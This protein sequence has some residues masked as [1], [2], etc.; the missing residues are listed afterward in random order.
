MARVIIT[1]SLFKTIQRTFDVAEADSILDALKSLE[2]NPYKGKIP[3]TVGGIVIKEIRHKK[4][5]FYCITDGH[6]LKFGTNEELAGLLIKFVRI[7]EKK[8]Q[9]K[10]ITEV[11]SILRSFGF[12]AW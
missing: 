7:S 6:M 11:K 4:Y 9:Q 10:T 2:T 1:E 5:R 3:G 12:D 8:D